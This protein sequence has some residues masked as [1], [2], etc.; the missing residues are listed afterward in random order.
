MAGASLAST[1]VQAQVIGD[2]PQA[3]DLVDNSAFFGDSLGEGNSGA[4]FADRF[5]FTVDDALGVNVDAI[6]GSVSRSADVG[7]DITGLWIYNGNDT[8]ISTGTSLQTGA[9]DVWT[10]AGD[11]LVAGDYYL[12]VDGNVVSGEG[13]SFGGAVMLAP[14]PEPET[15][16]MMLGGLGVLGFLARRRQSRRG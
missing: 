14:V 16:G 1:A 3:L 15:Y 12:R 11:N 6:V 7:L 2:S 4:T 13:A 8:L 9:V 10:V 5:T